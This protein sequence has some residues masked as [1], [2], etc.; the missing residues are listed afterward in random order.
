MVVY[1]RCNADYCLRC[2][3]R[4]L[5]SVLWIEKKKEKSARSFGEEQSGK[6][7]VAP[8]KRESFPFLP[9]ANLGYREHVRYP[10]TWTG[11]PTSKG[12]LVGRA[13]FLLLQ[14][15]GGAPGN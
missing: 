1:V 3:K 12:R 6:E 5:C 10:E 13:L 15:E 9:Y 4:V 14:S 8:K 7:A 11:W 2:R